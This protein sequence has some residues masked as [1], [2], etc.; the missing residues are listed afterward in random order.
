MVTIL[1]WIGGIGIALG[2]A[3]LVLKRARALV[4]QLTDVITD[5][6]RPLVGA[7]EE[8]VH[9][10]RELRVEVRRAFGSHRPRRAELPPA[11]GL[12]RPPV[13]DGGR[14]EER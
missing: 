6:V 1:A 3:V 2:S 10:L 8:L 7:V 11:E 12:V 13:R 5:H 9:A 4:L 14:R